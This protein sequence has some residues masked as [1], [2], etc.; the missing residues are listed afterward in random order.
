MVRRRFWWDAL[1]AKD[2]LEHLGVDGRIILKLIFK[3]WYAMAWTGLICFIRGTEG[4][5]M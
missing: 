3:M 5:C 1:R 4:G 2:H